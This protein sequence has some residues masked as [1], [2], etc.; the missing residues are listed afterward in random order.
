MTSSLPI[1]VTQAD[2]EQVL[3]QL[4]TVSDKEAQKLT[5]YIFNTA[6]GDSQAGEK[7]N[8]LDKNK[9]IQQLQIF[10][11]TTNVDIDILEDIV[12]ALSYAEP[13]LKN[14]FIQGLQDLSNCDIITPFDI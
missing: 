4:G 7:S 3:A 1:S 8:E 13:E 10:G 9:I 11:N 6:I 14:K 2:L 5:N 12:F